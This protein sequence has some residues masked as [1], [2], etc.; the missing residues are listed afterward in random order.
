MTDRDEHREVLDRFIG[1]ARSGDLD[2]LLE[3]SAPESVLVTDGGATLKAARHP[4]RGRARL[5]SVP[6]VDRSSACSRRVEVTFEDVNGE[7]GIVVREQG[8]VVLV[9]TAGVD[10][11][12]ISTVHWVRNPDK[13]RWFE[14]GTSRWYRLRSAPQGQART[15][16]PM[17]SA[18]TQRSGAPVPRAG[19]D[20]IGT[21]SVHMVI[22]RV[23]GDGT[24]R[25]RSRARRRWSD[26]ARA[27]GEMKE[28]EPAASTAASRR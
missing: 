2:R 12:R 13:L 19:G 22:A 15:L 4:I 3:G 14:P 28:L 17:T 9:G 8:T 11:G 24:L 21:N 26:W 18:V 23:V 5:R 20:R 6:G 27:S 7:L 16:G 25:G 10:A 1:A